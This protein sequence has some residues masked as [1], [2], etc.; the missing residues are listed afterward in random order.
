ML[1]LSA[2][3]S[4]ATIEFARKIG[5]PSCFQDLAICSMG[6]TIQFWLK[7]QDWAKSC[8]IVSNGAELTSSQGYPQYP[9]LSFRHENGQ[10]VLTIATREHFWQ[11]T[12]DLPEQNKW[13]FY[14][15]TFDRKSGVKLYIDSKLVGEASE[16][17]RRGEQGEVR[18][19]QTSLSLG[20]CP[21]RSGSPCFSRHVYDD[22][23]VYYASRD[24]LQ[25]AGVIFRDVRYN[26]RKQVF[27]FADIMKAVNDA[28]IP[29]VNTDDAVI[30]IHGGPEEVS[31]EEEGKKALR[32]GYEH[33]NVN[34]AP[35][36]GSCLEDINKCDNGVTMKTK[37]RF[38]NLENYFYLI[39]SPNF[40]VYY[41]DGS[42]NFKVDS[43]NTLVSR[44]WLVPVAVTPGKWYK[45]AASWHHNEG[46]SV[47][48]DDKL[49]GFQEDPDKVE[50][51][52]S[53]DDSMPVRGDIYVGRPHKALSG[54]N[55]HSVGSFDIETLEFEDTSME[56]AKDIK[57]A[58]NEVESR[59]FI[60]EAAVGNNIPSPD[61]T[62]EVH[63]NPLTMK[64]IGASKA[65]LLDDNKNQYAVL[66]P[67]TG[68]CFSEADVRTCSNGVTTSAWL[69]PRF[70][71]TSLTPFMMIGGKDLETAK[72]A[73][74]YKD[75]KL[76]AV[77]RTPT[78]EWHA[79]GRAPL[80]NLW[81]FYEVTW[82]PVFGLSVFANDTMIARAERPT[83]INKEWTPAADA[84]L[85]MSRSEVKGSDAVFSDNMM[86]DTKLTNAHR[87]AMLRSGII[88][89]GFNPMTVNRD[90]VDFS[91]LLPNQVGRVI[92]CG[93]SGMIITGAGVP[94]LDVSG[95]GGT[96]LK[97]EGNTAGKYVTP[98]RPAKHGISYNIKATFPETTGNH[99]FVE[100]KNFRLGSL[101]GVLVGTFANKGRA[102][103]V[104]LPS[105]TADQMY[106]LSF[107]FHPLVGLTLWQGG[108]FVYSDKRSSRVKIPHPVGEDAK[109]ENEVV[110][111]R[112]LQRGP[113]D[114]AFSKI[115]V[116]TLDITDATTEVLREQEGKSA[117]K[118]VYP[119]RKEISA[120]PD[121]R[122]TA[123]VPTTRRP[124]VID[125]TSGLPGTTTGMP[126]RLVGGKSPFEGRVEV[127]YK[128]S[129]G[130]VC[131]DQFND[132]MGEVICQ[133]LGYG[134]LEETFGSDDNRWQI[135]GVD[136]FGQGTGPINI[137]TTYFTCL[138][139]ETELSDCIWDKN[140][141]NDC[142]HDE[143]AGLRCRRP[144]GDDCASR[145]CFNGGTCTDKPWDYACTCKPGYT[146]KNCEIDID[147]CYSDPCRNNAECLDEINGYRCICNPGYAGV[148]CETDLD[149]CA[150]KPCLNGGSCTDKPNGY[151]CRCVTGFTGQ[152]CQINIDDCR[153]GPCMNNAQC[154]DGINS[155]SCI[156]P[157]GFTGTR[158]EINI[159]ECASNP[160]SHGVC[161]D[162]IAGYRCVCESDWDGP[163]CN[164]NKN[165]CGSDPCRN[166]A[167]CED[168][169][170]SYTCKCLPG[171]EGKDCEV[172]E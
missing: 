35:K 65:L 99:T 160:C 57:M 108:K 60:V 72:L 155:Y 156:C 148:N 163:N 164:I 133:K 80:L 43:P 33:T 50:H 170:N 106:D 16:P 58:S 116:V 34:I 69:M 48:V 143:D 8:C 70:L 124:V 52:D 51:G 94:K 140:K 105:F 107:S 161:H 129:W 75:S 77:V 125:P 55:K 139:G 2:D 136:L 89:R 121:A 159:D 91:T 117:I 96:L 12:A 19:L 36:K 141:E 109:E 49:A 24:R 9:G 131:D 87:G 10:L 21:A 132:V 11:L 5:K 154:V 79:E 73:M 7:A 84:K 150:S 152:N 134:P 29:T 74:Y 37:V 90:S 54:G 122:P 144:D 41:L 128:G 153:V 110:I 30:R 26:A 115:N 44:S 126:V 59:N 97:F 114:P 64:G 47:F 81:Q 56:V 38:H 88:Y 145:P 118:T 83:S 61:G 78:E 138:G 146:G 127:Y 93:S 63:G 45:L 62:F 13:H 120:G 112:G 167:P 17:Q 147:E 1:D 142:S 137:D 158:C 3:H 151:K 18:P 15:F 4:Y 157:R 40:A 86:G 14:E 53:L 162:E 103:S 111:G 149:E 23:K 171:Y 20:I 123:A 169:V 113:A 100:S 22:L 71:R 98:V 66:E 95:L 6:L 130:T 135:R 25:R 39:D 68:S 85:T 32:F 46:L 27:N 104:K 92:P 166:G 102:W 42:L 67:P 172:G 31:A 165:E 82:H 119:P 28:P 76:H 168:G 101:N